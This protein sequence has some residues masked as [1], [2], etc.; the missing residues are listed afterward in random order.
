LIIAF[1][2]RRPP[3]KLSI[4]IVGERVHLLSSERRAER[5][6]APIGRA[7]LRILR[8]VHRFL[9]FRNDQ[10]DDVPVVARPDAHLFQQAGIE[11]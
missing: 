1:G 4:R 3:S 9:D 8:H 2:G 6:A 7:S 11:A 10:H 5:A